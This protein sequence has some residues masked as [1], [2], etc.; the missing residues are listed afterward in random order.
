M[1]RLTSDDTKSIFYSLNLFFAKD[2]EVWI[3]GGG[4]EPDYQDCTLVNWIGRVADKHNLEIHARDA[5][6]LGDEMYDCLQDGIDTIEGI[7]ALLHAAAVQ[8]ATM[9]IRLK[10]I[11]DILGDD[12]D[13]DR[14]KELVEADRE[15]KCVVLP[16]KVGE[17][18]WEVLD[19]CNFP[20]DCHETQTC[21]GCEYREIFKEKLAFSL[22]MISQNGKL[23]PPYY[24][25]EKEAEA[26]LEKMKEGK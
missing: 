10:E 3:R 25:S 23:E 14:L 15:G 2:N 18:I 8:A 17:S 12:Y 22:Y 13:L 4:P 19:V 9:K 21:K 7:V 24:V 20:G 11:E 16:C 1:K 5:V 6:N 26:A